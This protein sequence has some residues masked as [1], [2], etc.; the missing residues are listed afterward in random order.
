MMCSN[1]CYIHASNYFGYFLS[2][3]P[4]NFQ[5]SPRPLVLQCL[6][7]IPVPSSHSPKWYGVFFPN[8]IEDGS[9]QHSLNLGQYGICST[10]V[11]GHR[12]ILCV[13]VCIINLQYA[14][15]THKISLP[16]KLNLTSN[17]FELSR[18]RRPHSDI[19]SLYTIYTLDTLLR[20]RSRRL[21]ISPKFKNY[22]K[23]CFN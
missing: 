3:L 16:P 6:P 20:T 4:T 8:M 10:E 19:S 22:W 18:L 5:P 12:D 1:Y 9:W 15:T 7:L 17:R 23:Y 11:K 21:S 13:C 2:D 14:A